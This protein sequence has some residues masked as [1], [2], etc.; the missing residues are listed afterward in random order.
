MAETILILDDSP[1]MM[2]SIESVLKKIGVIVE[3]PK[4]ANRRWAG[5]PRAS[6]RA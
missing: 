3:R 2:M 1:T 6:S 5:C 4:A